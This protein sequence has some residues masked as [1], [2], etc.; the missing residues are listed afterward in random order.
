MRDFWDARARENALYYVDNR[1]DFRDPDLEAFWETGRRTLE[2]ILERVGTRVEPADE[3]VE[4]GC[5][6]GRVTRWLAKEAA[7]VRALDVSAEM[8]ARAR[9]LNAGLANVTW[10]LGDGESL[11]PIADSSAD[12]VFS[13]VV[14]QHIPDPA[15]QLGYVREIGRV[16]RPGGRAAFQI[17]ND[18]AVHGRRPLAER[19]RTRARALVGRGPSGQAHPAWLG[20]AMDLDDLR[21]VAREAGMEVERVAGE[22]EQHCHVLLRRPG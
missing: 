1:V 14:F 6:V 20:A 17:S 16:L 5:G 13:D 4:I 8:L 9:E 21:R 22:G 10:L 15:V 12:L 19:V 11:A 2:V 3:A 7:T 18:P